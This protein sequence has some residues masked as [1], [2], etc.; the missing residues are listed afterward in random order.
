MTG[1]SGDPVFQRRLRINR[2][3]A[4]Y[5]IVRSSRTMTALL[6]EKRNDETIHRRDD[7]DGG[8]R[9]RP[10]SPRHLDRTAAMR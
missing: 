10:A 7:G 9:G 2:E 6:L 5:W 3:A 8:F 4:A 1:S